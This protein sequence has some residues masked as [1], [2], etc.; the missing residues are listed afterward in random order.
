MSIWQ[1]NN[2]TQCINKIDSIYKPAKIFLKEENKQKMQRAK[3]KSGGKF[4]RPHFACAQTSTYRDDKLRHEKQNN[5]ML[6]N[7]PSLAL[8]PP[9]P[10]L[11]L[12]LKTEYG[13]H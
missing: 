8:S 5:A 1:K 3:T 11:A 9:P 10:L 12:Y 4:H 6:E 13:I 7:A 2:E